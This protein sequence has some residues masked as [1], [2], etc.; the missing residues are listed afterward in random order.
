MS[1]FVIDFIDN[2]I[3][4]LWLLSLTVTHMSFNFN[5]FVLNMADYLAMA[6]ARMPIV[7]SLGGMDE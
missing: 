4:V 6:L 7:D 3:S 2:L 5:T 1:L